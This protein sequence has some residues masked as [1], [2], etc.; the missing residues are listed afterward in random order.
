MRGRQLNQ[1]VS[2]SNLS[3]PYHSSKC[4]LLL[5]PRRTPACSAAWIGILYQQVRTYAGRVLKGAKPVDLPLQQSTKF[6][7]A[8]NLK[9]AKALGPTVPPRCSH[10][11]TK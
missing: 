9:T 2:V 5:T 6:E 3:N 8:I 10:A 7:L 11:P 4:E 1:W